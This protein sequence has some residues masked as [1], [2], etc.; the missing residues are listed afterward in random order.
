LHEGGNLREFKAEDVEGKAS[1]V[2][3]LLGERKPDAAHYEIICAV[4][5]HGPE[6]KLPFR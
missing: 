4:D 5:T 2:C 6:F 3:R 1:E